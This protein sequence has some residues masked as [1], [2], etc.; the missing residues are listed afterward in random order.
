MNIKLLYYIYLMEYQPN[1]NSKIMNL[2]SSSIDETNSE[3][4][5]VKICSKKSYAKNNENLIDVMNDLEQKVNPKSFTEGIN[6][7]NIAIN[8][9]NPSSLTSAMDAGYKEFEDRVGRPMTYAE[10]RSMWG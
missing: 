2:L 6:Q 4:K 7:L 9:N 8:T 1:K 10:M 5:N 3:I